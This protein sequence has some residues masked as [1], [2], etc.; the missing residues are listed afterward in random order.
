VVEN[1]TLPD[2]GSSESRRHLTPQPY[3]VLALQ[4][5]EPTAGSARFAL[6]GLQDVVI[7]RGEARR[8]TEVIADGAL[9]LRVEVNDR[10]MSSEHARLRP[11]GRAWQLLDAGSMNG[12]FV[13]GRR[14][15]RAYLHDGDLVEVGRTMFVYRSAELPDELPRETAAASL[16]E[17]PRA[18]RTLSGAFASELEALVRVARTAVP[19]AI[20]GPTGTGKELT[21]RAVHELSGRPGAFVAVNCGAIAATLLEGELFGHTK[22][23]FSG[24]TEDRPGLIRAADGGTLL[25]DEVAELPAAAQVALLRALQEREVVPVGA[26]T[27]VAVDLRVVT[28]THRDLAAHVDAGEF[29]D[30]LYARLGGH[31]ITLPALAERR[32]DLGLLI[33]DALA[34]IGPRTFTRGAARSLFAYDWPR[35]VRELHHVLETAAATTAGQAIELAALPPG[36]RETRDAL[37]TTDR[38]DARAA[39]QRAEIIDLLRA[40]EGNV[41]AAARALGKSRGHL[42]RLL[43]KL[44]I[45][46]AD[47]RG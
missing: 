43:A 44:G 45:D 29:R 31:A 39:A 20:Y 24:A 8:A 18:M 36:I 10:R 14:V 26:T 40:H 41:T 23:A 28:A 46:A 35:N 38:R 47:Y 42:H 12:T 11:A 22:G 9:G 33:A 1:T 37:A 30:D 16:A 19:I 3:L 21:A 7:G 4:Y 17:L 15:P 6:A 32:E 2:T 27:P 25:L 13:N 5:E 34:D